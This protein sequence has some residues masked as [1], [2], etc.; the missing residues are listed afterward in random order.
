MTREGL[1][2]FD[3]YDD[4]L[5]TDEDLVAK[6]FAVVVQG[7][8]CTS[9]TVSPGELDRGRL[10]RAAVARNQGMGLRNLIRLALEKQVELILLFS[11]THVL[12]SEA[13]RRCQGPEGYWNWL[14][15]IVSIAAQEAGS[16]SRQIQ[17]WQFADYALI[18]GERIHA[19][20]AAR[21]RLWQDSIHFNEEVGGAAFDAI[22]SGR[23]GYGA[24]VTVE[25]FELT[26]P[27][28]VPTPPIVEAIDDAAPES[29][30]NRPRV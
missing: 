20:K 13:Q 17:V 25:N 5:Q 7:A 24:R 4:R 6:N 15:Q 18:N 26:E 30:E 11:P 2:Y 8:L 28:A 9:L 27:A 14:W 10:H 19:G 22:Y 16:N 3:R 21:D 1:W 23:P 29:F 12:M